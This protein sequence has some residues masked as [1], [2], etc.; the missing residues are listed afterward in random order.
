MAHKPDT[1]LAHELSEAALQVEVGVRYTHFK[2]PSKEY[3]VTGFA[4]LE[5]DDSVAVLYRAL[6]GDGFTFAR[7]LSSWCALVEHEGEMV[8]RFSKSTS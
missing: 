7:A 2:D 5:A 1:E 6:Y 8:P 3:E 4:V